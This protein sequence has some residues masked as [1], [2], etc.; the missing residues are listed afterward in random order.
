MTTSATTEQ[1][2]GTEPELAVFA[3]LIR[4]RLIPEVDF[5][6][7]SNL[8]GGRLLKGGLV[9]DFLFTNPPNLA[10]SVAGEYWHFGRGIEVR[11]KDL[12]ARAIL[13]SES[14]TLIFIEESHALDNAE[15]YVGEAL[16]FTDHSRLR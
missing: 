1:V 12:L 14:I 15:F 11:A 13:A 7:Q 8:F 10:I 5:T 16:R 3:E 9:I 4:R 2:V 6:F